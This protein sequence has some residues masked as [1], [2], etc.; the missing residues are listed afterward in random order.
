MQGD[1]I[2]RGEKLNKKEQKE[3]AALSKKYLK[4]TTET[5]ALLKNVDS[6]IASL[7]TKMPDAPYK[8]TDKWARYGHLVGW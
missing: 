3:F 7:I 1:R 2:A 5:E 4:F 8:S 6:E